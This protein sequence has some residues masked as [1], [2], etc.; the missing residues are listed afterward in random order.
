ME[1]ACLKSRD[2]NHCWYVDEVVSE[3]IF[4]EFQVYHHYWY[5]QEELGEDACLSFLD[6]N[7]YW[8]FQEEVGELGEV[9]VPSNRQERKRED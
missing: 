5:V 9:D 2:C 8:C 4:L 7:H 6:C 3:D 1:V